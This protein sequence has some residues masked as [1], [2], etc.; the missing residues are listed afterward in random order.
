MEEVKSEADTEA[1]AP[2]L[3]EER[4]V[5]R[6]DV[7]RYLDQVVPGVD[8]RI[9]ELA[10]LMDADR[11]SSHVG[12]RGRARGVRG[13]LHCSSGIVDTSTHGA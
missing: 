3:Q 12:G 2:L 10:R 9:A 8:E 6:Q 7:V 11:G 4:V 1:G 5:H 13:E